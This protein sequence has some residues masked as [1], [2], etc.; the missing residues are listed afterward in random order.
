[1]LGTVVRALFSAGFAFFGGEKICALL[2]EGAAGLILFCNLCCFL[3]LEIFAGAKFHRMVTFYT[4][5]LNINVSK[6]R[7]YIK[8]LNSHGNHHKIKCTRSELKEKFCRSLLSS[9]L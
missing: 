6:V 1:M 3:R 9:Q 5:K 8:L 2:L 4:K 7:Y